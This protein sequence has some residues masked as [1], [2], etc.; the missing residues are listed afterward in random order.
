MKRPEQSR[1]VASQTGKSM[2][3]K[4]TWP[5]ETPASLSDTVFNQ[6]EKEVFKSVQPEIDKVAGDLYFYT[7][8]VRNKLLIDKVREQLNPTQ[9]MFRCSRGMI[10]LTDDCIFI[11]SAYRKAQTN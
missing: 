9:L 3:V 1:E 8:K 2:F 10:I 4:S 11:F 6:I 7:Y 5:I